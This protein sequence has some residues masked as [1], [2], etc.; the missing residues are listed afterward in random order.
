FWKTPKASPKTMSIVPEILQSRK[1][2][3][4]DSVKSVAW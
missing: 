3:R 4:W 1:N 2:W